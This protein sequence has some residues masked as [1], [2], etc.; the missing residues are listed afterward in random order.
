MKAY[1]FQEK[2]A[3]EGM[4]VNDPLTNGNYE[5]TCSYYNHVL[6]ACKDLR[7]HDL[8]FEDKDLDSIMKDIFGTRFFLMMF[9]TTMI[10]ILKH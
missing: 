1:E 10:G 6:E 4:E 2:S 7:N 3:R 5:Y 8:H 9:L